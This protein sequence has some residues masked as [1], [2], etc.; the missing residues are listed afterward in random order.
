M[1]LSRLKLRTIIPVTVIGIFLPLGTFI[2][3]MTYTE[4]LSDL[5]Q[6]SKAEFGRKLSEL[7]LQLDPVG[8]DG[9]L[10]E[11]QRLLSAAG[12]ADGMQ[13]LSLVGRDEKIIASTH[14]AW[15]GKRVDSVWNQFDPK[16]FASLFHG[17]THEVISDQSGIAYHAYHFT[18]LRG[19]PGQH[20]RSV[21]Q[22]ALVGVFDYKKSKVTLERRLRQKA[23]FYFIALLFSAG[24]ITFLLIRLIS[25]PVEQ[26]SKFV[27]SFDDAAFGRQV[28]I[29]GSFEMHT[30]GVAVNSMSTTLKTYHEQIAVEISER[31]HT[32]AVL[33]R[34]RSALDSSADSVYIIDPEKMLFIDLN[35]TAHESLGYSKEEML[36]M[37]PQDIK[38]DSNHCELANLIT[39]VAESGET[40]TFEAMHQRKDGS[41]FP[42]EV[43]LRAMQEEHQ[44]PVVIASVRDV[45]AR[46]AGE[47]ELRKLS[48]AIQQAGEAVM[49]TD[50]HAVIEYVNPA[51][52]RITGYR[53]EE[54]I[55][56]TPS[57]LRSSAQDPQFYKELWATITRGDVWQGTLTDRKK[58]GSFYPAMMSVAPIHDDAGK[59]THYLSIQ[60]DMTEYKKLEEQFLQAQKMEA[61]GT[62]VGGIAHDFNNLLAG[63]TGNA[64]LA[65][66]RLDD[67][68]PMR[69]NID[70]ISTLGYRGADMIKQLL[71]FARKGSV[72]MVP[73]SLNTFMQEGHQLART[74][75]PE[76]MAF[77]LEI[78]PEALSIDGDVT[79]LQQLIMNLTN[80]ARDA[81]AGTTHPEITCSLQPFTADDAFKAAHP[82]ATAS[83]FAL[84]TVCDNGPGIQPEHLNKVF[85]P[86]FSTKGVGEGTGL[87]LSM[88]Y[89]CVQ[90]HGGIIQ[91]E[92][93]PGS[94]T[95][96]H[97][98]LPLINATAT[99]ASESSPIV[100]GRG[101]MIL[102]VDDEACMLETSGEVL[103]SMSY[104]VIEAADGEQAL[105][106]F[107][108][109]K[110]DIALIITDIVMPKMGGI[111]L[112]NAVRALGADIPIIFATGY[113]KEH[114][115][116]GKSTIDQSVIMNKPFSF[117]LLS[118]HIRRLLDPAT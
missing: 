44:Q 13:H 92:S 56:N 1:P 51:F 42:V 77:R 11:A 3:G 24:L 99:P 10:I 76:S 94:R 62:L 80:N 106:L 16:L 6:S 82:E 98:Y 14:F 108:R 101:E 70:T 48:Q 59:T 22:A 37:G 30:L 57:M 38:P 90:M 2:I 18:R 71:T 74:A 9:K 83:S 7:S 103:R 27:A 75:I 91:V 117:E 84:I 110:S 21:R 17:S 19:Q 55:G 35:R 54:A 93:E 28:N 25:R 104:E 52:T 32:E 87:G 88:V 78:C 68:R 69:A 58:D 49:I 41:H 89:G 85:E 112:A 111:D 79:Q 53:A 34:F 29:T 33:R 26:L 20:I 39:A 50:I 45:T 81:V 60:Q 61:I 23:T 95:A 65:K 40:R 118:Q 43:F 12:A 64:F 73:V 66:K 4:S 97:I 107:R 31:K 47:A 36:S 72:R 105:T 67:G 100:S 96:F 109:H 115:F 102:L 46:K 113:D 63:I 5:K 86:F 15:I 8:E 114:A 116:S